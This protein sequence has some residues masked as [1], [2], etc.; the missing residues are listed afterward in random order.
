MVKIISAILVSLLLLISQPASAAR[1][2][3]ESEVTLPVLF[4][5]KLKDLVH[6]LWQ[7][8]DEKNAPAASEAK[9]L[10]RLSDCRVQDRKAL[11]LYVNHGP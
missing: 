2:G 9:E 6:G 5:K 8:M 3:L 11:P 10:A 1:Y 4:Q 7:K